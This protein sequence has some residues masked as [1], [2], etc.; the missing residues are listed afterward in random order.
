MI[1]G[2]DSLAYLS[3]EGLVKAV[4]WKIKK[5]KNDIG[6]CTAC[7]TGEYPE[8]PDWW[9]LREKKLL[10]LLRNIHNFWVTFLYFLKYKM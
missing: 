8:L 7:L 3:V 4:R 9:N 2:A 10:Q 6:H 1:T 5:G